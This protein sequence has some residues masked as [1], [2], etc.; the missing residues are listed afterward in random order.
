[1]DDDFRTIFGGLP[2]DLV[3]LILDNDLIC[4]LAFSSRLRFDFVDVA[5][6]RDNVDLEVTV[7][8]VDDGDAEFMVLDLTRLGEGDVV[9][10]LL[11]EF[12]ARSLFGDRLRCN[13]VIFLWFLE[14]DERS[15]P[16]TRDFDVE[17]DSSFFSSPRSR[18]LERERDNNEAVTRWRDLERSRDVD[19]PL[20]RRLWFWEDERAWE[21]EERDRDECEPVEDLSRSLRWGFDF[22]VSVFAMF[23]NYWFQ[24]Y[25][26]KRIE[27]IMKKNF[28]AK[29]TTITPDRNLLV[30][31]QFVWYNQ[32][33]CPK[34]NHFNLSLFNCLSHKQQGRHLGA[35]ITL[36][37][38]RII[39][40]SIK[41]QYSSSVATRSTAITINRT[42]VAMKLTLLPFA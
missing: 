4:V 26:T 20:S 10:D 18:D 3:E 40:P 42:G 41:D 17:W 29:A 14:P 22:L 32:H 19:V 27:L 7:V 23:V 8:S 11:S 39:Y 16:S 9:W 28:T 37:S 38:L 35:V 12:L 15:F 2:G 31:N 1:M 5:E 6:S 36:M 25:E 33:N 30:V 34:T 24:I 13:E 21:E